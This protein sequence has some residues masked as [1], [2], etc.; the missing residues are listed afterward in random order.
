[1]KNHNNFDIKTKM[2]EQNENSGASEIKEPNLDCKEEETM[3]FKKSQSP[4][5]S[6]CQVEQL[7]SKTSEL[8]VSES[9]TR[10]G[11]IFQSKMVNGNNQQGQTSKENRKRSLRQFGKTVLHVLESSQ[12][13]VLK[14]RRV[15]EPKEHT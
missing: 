11:K 10:S 8:D 1:M 4:S 14:K 5:I 7:V 2:N 3:Q 6:H 9:K 13:S 12:E 15:S